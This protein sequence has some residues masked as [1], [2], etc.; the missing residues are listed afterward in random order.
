MNSAVIKNAK[1]LSWVARCCLFCGLA[2]AVQTGWSANQN[3]QATLTGDDVSVLKGERREPR[4]LPFATTPNFEA[5][6]RGDP[7][8]QFNLGM[9]YEEGKGVSRNYAEAVKWLRKAAERGNAAAQCQLGICYFVGEGVAENA[10]EAAQWYRKAAEQRH[11]AGQFN[12]GCCYANGKGVAKDAAEAVRWYRKAAEQ[13]FAKAQ[14]N[15]GVCH[16]YGYG[17]TLDRAAAVA[18]YR[19]AAEQGLATAQRNLGLCYEQGNGVTQDVVEAYKWLS[20]AAAQG[21]AAAKQRR[22]ELERKMTLD[23]IAEAQR[24]PESLSLVP[25]SEEPPTT[26]SS[27]ALELTLETPKNVFRTSEGVSFVVNFHNHTST[28]LLLNGGALL[29]NGA[30]IW[31]SLE[32][33]L[34]SESGQRIPMTLGLG[35]PVAGRIYFLG[36]PLRAGSSYKLFVGARDYFAGAGG[37]LRAGKYELRCIYHGRQSP[38]RDSTQMPGCWEGKVQSNILKIKVLRS[39]VTGLP[40]FFSHMWDVIR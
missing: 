31:S 26:N 28:N 11:A 24:L 3:P 9:C 16:E 23:Q 12:L 25:W 13:G 21:N 8:A 22:A 37:V 35:I 32:A 17:A 19:K 33:E 39:H 40:S 1:S 20:L 4:S 27:A 14:Y 7:E 34:K 10:T 30:Q 6:E 15:L 29:G 2:W 36:V 38:Y 18:W 5:A